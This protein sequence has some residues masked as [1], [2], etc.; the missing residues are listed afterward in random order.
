MDVSFGSVWEAVARRLPDAVAVSEPGRELTYAQFEDRSARLAAALA[1]AGVGPGDNVACYLYNGAAYLETV[2]AA[3]KLGAVPVNANYRYTRDE[4][5]SLLRDADAA[6][7]VFSGE[8][9]GNVSD[10]AR[11]VPTLRLL[12]RVGPASAG[13]A[14]AELEEVLRSVAPRPARPRPGSDQLFMYTGGTT[15]RPKGVIWRHADL[16]HS[17]LVP[18]FRPLGAE[19]LPGTLDEAVE[20]AVSAHNTGLAPVTMPVVPLMHGTGLFNSM[21]ALLTGGQVVTTRRG[22]LDPRH[23]WETVAERRVGTMIVAGNAVCRPLVDELVAAEQAGRPHGLGSLRSVIS[24]GTALSDDLKRALHERAAVT[25]VD[26]IA[27]TE[28]GPFAFAVTSSAGDLPA[29]FFPVPVTKV[30]T[31]EGEEVVP[32]SGRTGVLAYAGPM[33]LGYYK[34]AAR[35]STTFRVLDG[36][37]YTVPGDLAQVAPDGALRFLG[38]GSGAINTG[39][40]KVHPQEV[41]DVLLAHPDVTDCVVLGMRDEIWGERVAAVVA[42]AGTLTEREIQ[43]WA[44]RDLAGYKVPRR[45]AFLPQL[46]RTPTGKLELA[47]AREVLEALPR[48]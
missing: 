33:P 43:D 13:P 17:L 8:L 47:W 19:A 41:E 45:V 21:G 9:A 12:V 27:S 3:F 2:F 11:H 39:G 40:E 7:L 29:R 22:A 35:T 42:T 15:G 44:R 5:S 30:L 16:L 36:V 38:R 31:D 18:I 14:A 20:I 1:A 46:R 24:S 25:V 37:R 23:V 10:A 26:A 28:G 32:G 4:L 34:D 48:D 6:A